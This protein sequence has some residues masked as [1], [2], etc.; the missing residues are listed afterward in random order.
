MITAQVFNR[1]VQIIDVYKYAN[2]KWVRVRVLQGEPFSVW[3]HGG[4]VVTDS[5]S[6]MMEFLKDIALT[7]DLSVEVNQ[8]ITARK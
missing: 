6:V 4:W 8:P 2:R 1:R 5:T 3:T 7:V